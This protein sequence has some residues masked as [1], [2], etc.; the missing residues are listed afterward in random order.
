MPHRVGDLL[1]AA[2]PALAER[3]LAA[4][5]KL[6]EDFRQRVETDEAFRNSAKE[7]LRWFYMKTPFR[8]D[9]WKLYPIAREE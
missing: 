4:D 8:D 2:V 6:A 5:A 3:M 7:R 9:R 1:T